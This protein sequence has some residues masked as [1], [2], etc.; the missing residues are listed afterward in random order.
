MVKQLA[1]T[2]QDYREGIVLVMDNLY[3]HP[4]A[5]LDEALQVAEARRTAERLETRRTP[6]QG[7]G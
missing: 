2:D 3:P 7:G 1:H 4:A 6:K 5:L